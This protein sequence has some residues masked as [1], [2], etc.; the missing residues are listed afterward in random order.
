MSGDSAA[1]SSIVVVVVFG[2]VFLCGNSI[3]LYSL[4]CESRAM[5]EN[6]LTVILVSPLRLLKSSLLHHKEAHFPCGDQDT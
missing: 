3:L 4:N 6:P 1:I 2:L 5:Y